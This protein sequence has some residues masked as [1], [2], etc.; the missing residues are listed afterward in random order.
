MH[1]CDYNMECLRAPGLLGRTLQTIQRFT[2]TAIEST[3]LDHHVT[4]A[5]QI[6]ST[7]Q[8]NDDLHNELYCQLV[9]QT[10]RHS[11]QHKTAMQVLVELSALRPIQNYRAYYAVVPSSTCMML[12]SRFRVRCVAVT[13]GSSATPRHQRHHPAR[14]STPAT[15]ASTPQPTSS[16]RRGSCCVWRCRF[17][18]RSR[19]PCGCC[20]RTSR[21]TPTPG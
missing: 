1:V 4:L 13:R 16:C 10:S 14:R 11:V 19:T 17:S 3:K 8:Q 21:V 6:L 5:Q 20:R 12:R 15:R 2:T 7:C 18:C 9:K